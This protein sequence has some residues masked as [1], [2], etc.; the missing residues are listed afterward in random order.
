MP[1]LRKNIDD[2]WDNGEVGD[3]A[4]R[5]GPATEESPAVVDRYI[6]IRLPDTDS[7]SGYKDFAVLPLQTSDR[8]DGQCWQWDGNREAPTLTPSILHHSVPPW[9]GYMRA[10]KLEVA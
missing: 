5:D 10:G 8:P 6:V 2:L 7:G 1:Q 3:W 9:H 4:F